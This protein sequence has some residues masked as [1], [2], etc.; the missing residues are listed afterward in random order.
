MILSDSA[1][2]L[3]DF[4]ENYGFEAYAV[5]GCVR[6]SIMNRL[7]DD[8]D[9]TTSAKPDELEK[10]LTDH[11]IR[12]IET[13]IKHGTITVIYK[14]SSFEVTTFRTDRRAHV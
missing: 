5:G 9:I 2:E 4:I 7:C 11:H 10:I 6:D 12:F 8:V 14:N 13:G 3:I 1:K